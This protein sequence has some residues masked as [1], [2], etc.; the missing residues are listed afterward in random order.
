MR[1]IVYDRPGSPDVLRL[2]DRPTPEPADG[3]VRVR[4]ALSG[5]NPTDWKSRTRADPGPG[6]QVPGQDG[7]GTVDAV[8]PGVDPAR[9]GERVWV[10][11]AAWERPHG[12]AAEFT[13]VPAAQAVPLPG[14]A[15]F[16]LGAALGIPFLTAHRCLTVA[17][18]GPDRLAPGTLAGR[19]VLAQGGAGAVGN[20]VTQLARWAGAIVISTVSSPEKASLAQAAGAHHVVDYRRQDVA[21]QVRA[22]A[23]GGVDVVAEV[24]PAVN[25]PAVAGLLAPLGT[26]AIYADDGGAETTLPV[27]PQ[28]L[29]NSRWQHVYVY[30]VPRR[31]KESAVAAV[32]AALADGA[33]RVG[34]DAGLPLHVVP[35]DRTADAHR[36]VEGGGVVGKMLVDVTA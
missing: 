15:G 27:R 24:A 21:E 2:T 32:A 22:I 14:G 35:L 6:G 36:A 26:V 12:T 8:G 31:A 16:E 20:A 29:L 28:M 3:E 34:A 13:V 7:A 33:L 4:L 18:E 23:P 19:T 5:V 10:W 17:E 30:T 1:A 25:A 11:E 9:I